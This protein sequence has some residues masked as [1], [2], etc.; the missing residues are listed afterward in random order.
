MQ[1]SAAVHVP[2][3]GLCSLVGNGV[4][5]SASGIHTEH[6]VRLTADHSRSALP[7]GGC[8]HAP[9]QALALPLHS[10]TLPRPRTVRPPP[11]CAFAPHP[12]RPFHFRLAALA[13]VLSPRGMVTHGPPTP[14]RLTVVRAFT[15]P[16]RC[17]FAFHPPAASL[18]HSVIGLH[19]RSARLP[20]SVGHHP[21]HPLRCARPQSRG[22]ETRSP[23]PSHHA[24][25]SRTLGHAHTVHP[26]H[27]IMTSLQTAVGF[28]SPTCR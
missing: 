18:P 16:L 3:S 25:V 11:C 26:P 6:Q 15:L 17:R 14:P 20:P 5:L 2:S 28:K 10:V 1:T 27:A 22:L 21:S 12:R 7:C 13:V 4:P 23:L 8:S 19:Y 24:T 9:P